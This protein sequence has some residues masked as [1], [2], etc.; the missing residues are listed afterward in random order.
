MHARRGG[1]CPRVQLH[2]RSTQRARVCIHRQPEGASLLCC[3]VPQQTAEVRVCPSAAPSS[4]SPSLAYSEPRQAAAHALQ[5]PRCGSAEAAPAAWPSAAAA[6]ALT[7]AT[8]A[9][10]A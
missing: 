2:P 7:A 4:A 9:V 1:P 8:V 6:A 10:T 3:S 5:L